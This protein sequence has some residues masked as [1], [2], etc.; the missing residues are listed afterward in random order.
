MIR[1]LLVCGAAALVATVGITGCTTSVTVSKDQVENAIETNLG[2]QLPAPIEQVECPE[3]L[4]GEVGAQMNCTLTMQGQEVGVEVT[5]T[6]VEDRDV[7]FDM[8]TV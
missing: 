1:K 4:K 3:D 8:R 6:S 2:P 5:V 7:N